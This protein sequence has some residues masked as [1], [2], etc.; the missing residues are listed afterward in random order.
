LTLKK[1][2]W[3]HPS[4]EEKAIL[5]TLFAFDA[6]PPDTTIDLVLETLLT[7]WDGWTKKKIRDA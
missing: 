7:Y 4:K 5:E 1:A 6:M 2:K 3:H